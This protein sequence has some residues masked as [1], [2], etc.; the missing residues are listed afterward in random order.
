MGSGSKVVNVVG[1]SGVNPND[2]HFEAQYN[3]EVSFL[4]NQGG[5]FCPNYPR[6]SGNQGWNRERDD[7]W[8]DRDREWSDHGTNWKEREGDKEMAK[9]KVFGGNQPPRK[10][11]RGIVINEGVEPSLKA[12]TKLPQTGGKE[13]YST[14]EELVPKGKKKANAFKTMDYVVVW[15]KK[16]K[17]ISI[18]INEVL[19]CTMDVMHYYIDLIQKKTLDDLK[20]WLALLISDT[21]PRCIEVGV[22]IK[23]RDLNVAARYWFGFISNTIMPLQNESILRHPKVACLGCI[24]DRERLNL[25]LLI[26]QE[27]D[28]RD[29]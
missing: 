25:G 2:T 23:K 13:F 9:P 19:G 15:G 24:L 21:T 8:R 29:K 4:A 1:V 11:A 26:E 28:M 3:E 7:S 22:P 16:V 20:G 27:M 17:C 10:Q 12:P 18:E 5:G 14:F 6:S